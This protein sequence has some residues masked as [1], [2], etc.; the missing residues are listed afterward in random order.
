MI[1]QGVT[2]FGVREYACEHLVLEKTVD[3]WMYTCT[4]CGKTFL[5]EEVENR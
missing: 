1:A 4:E 2:E 5:V 3:Q